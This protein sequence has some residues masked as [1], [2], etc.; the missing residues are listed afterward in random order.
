MPQGRLTPGHIASAASSTAAEVL[1]SADSAEE[2]T[3][4]AAYRSKEQ[5]SAAGGRIVRRDMGGIRDV[6]GFRAED[7]RRVRKG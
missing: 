2:V 3:F 7:L 6:C 5:A 4:R 1:I